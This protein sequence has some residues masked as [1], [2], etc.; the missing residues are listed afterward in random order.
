MSNKQLQ[1]SLK[2]TD[3]GYRVGETLIV[4][5]PTGKYGSAHILIPMEF[6]GLTLQD[7]IK[8]HHFFQTAKVD[9]IDMNVSNDTSDIANDC[10]IQIGGAQVF[11]CILSNRLNASSDSPSG[12]FLF[13]LLT[14][15]DK[16]NMSGSL[17]TPLK[18]YGG[19]AYSCQVTDLTINGKNVSGSSTYSGVGQFNFSR[20]TYDYGEP[21]ADTVLFSLHA[22]YYGTKQDGCVAK[23][24][25]IS[26]DDAIIKP[27]IANDN[28]KIGFINTK[29]N[30]ICWGYNINENVTVE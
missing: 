19:S 18:K 6:F 4:K 8:T 16:T 23:V 24:S 22:Y 1:I 30:Q 11:T 29:N 3:V 2:H 15:D 21:K 28:S 10:A 26:F 9:K 7:Y 27:I 20:A 5:A 25:G 14:A 17:S 13:E 12:N